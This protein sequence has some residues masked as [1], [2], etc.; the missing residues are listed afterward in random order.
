MSAITII[1]HVVVIVLII[2][3]ASCATPWDKQQADVHMNV[4]IAYLGGERFTDAL[5]EFLQAEKIIPRDP[6]VHYYKGIAY[7]GK[8]L[9]E[10]AIEEFKKTLSLKSD[11][12]EVHNYLGYIY[13]RKGRWDTAIECFKKALSNILYETPEKAYFNMGMAY[14]GKGDYPM[15]LSSYEKAKNIKPNSVPLPLIDLHM[16][17][18]YYA[19][20]DL[21]RAVQHFKESIKMAPSLLESRYWLGQCYIKQRDFEKAR[22]EFMVIIERA[23][24][25]DLG[26]AARK[27]LKT[28][29]SQ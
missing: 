1:R 23:P 2:T 24:D 11:Y 14:H 4:G 21:E 6:R 3:A 19:K 22:K 8:G 12:S 18:T 29:D 15:A 28:I 7:L 26:A 16:G 17:V 5:K 9:E 20:V 10:K 27:S 25:S 13:L